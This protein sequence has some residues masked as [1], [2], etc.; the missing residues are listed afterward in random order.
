MLQRGFLKPS[1]KEESTR[2]LIN[3][4]IIIFIGIFVS[5]AGLSLFIFRMQQMVEEGNNPIVN[6]LLL[7]AG[8]VIVTVGLLMNFFSQNRKRR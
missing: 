5:F 8:F 3:S 6:S 7:I 4:R 1:E 2:S